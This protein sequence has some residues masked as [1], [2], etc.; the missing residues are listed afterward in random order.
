M[1]QR[2]RF[3][4][5]DKTFSVVDEQGIWFFFDEAF[6][7][8]GPVKCYLLCLLLEPSEYMWWLH[9]L[10]L[11]DTSEQLADPPRLGRIGAFVAREGTACVIARH[12]ICRAEGCDLEK[13][14]TQEEDT[15]DPIGDGT[16]T[17]FIRACRSF[18][19]DIATT[20]IVLV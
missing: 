1:P 3:T 9:G 11:V 12:Q 19:E 8:N 13:M 18:L 20:R 2:L 15:K 16:K 5:F 7:L 10:V 4:A 17:L 14:K 6:I